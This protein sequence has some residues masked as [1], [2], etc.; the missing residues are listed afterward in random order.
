MSPAAWEPLERHLDGFECIA[1]SLPGS[2]D[3]VGSH[4][5]VTMRTFA[6][7]ADELL[8]E[9]DV[10]RAHVLG[11]S[12]GG[13]VGQ[14]LALDAPARVRKLV[15]VSTSCGLGAAPSNPAIWWN[16]MLGAALPFCTEGLPQ[17]TPCR[18]WA[19]MRRELGA[20]YTNSLWLSGLAQQMA[21][22]SLWSSLP[23]LSRLTHETLVI[24][25]TADALVPAQNA[26]ILA[27]SMP[28]A[29]LYHVWGGGHLCLLDRVA[30]VGP[31]I[32]D[33]LRALELTSVDEAVELH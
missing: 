4:A 23:W 19:V 29:G 1:V 18:W 32:A 28:R 7:L 5:L 9:L 6:A 17:W 21:A 14:Q 24:T 16:A 30:E 26:W 15:L 22:A 10:D 33:F 12:F 11:F 27:S 20:G 8:N 25:G 31:V 13:M 3:G 2:S